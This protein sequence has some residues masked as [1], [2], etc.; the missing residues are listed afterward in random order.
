MEGLSSICGGLGIIEEDD[1]GNPI[2]YSKGEYCL[3]TVK[4]R[5][6]EKMI[7]IL[8]YFLFIDN[9]EMIFCIFI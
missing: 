7:T 4:F 1:D 8:C 5:R 2:G 9:V 3:G 6:K